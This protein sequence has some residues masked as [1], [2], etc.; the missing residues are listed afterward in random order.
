MPSLLFFVS[1][2]DLK[3]SNYFGG[4]FDKL[5]YIADTHW[6]VLVIDESHEGVNT[7]KTDTAFNY[8]HR[9]HMLYLSGTPFKALASNEFSEDQI[10]NWTYT[11]EQEA[12]ENWQGEGRNPYE[13]MPKLNLF[14]YRMS[15]IA[16]DQIEQGLDING[17]TEEYAFDLNEFFRTNESGHFVHLDAVKQ[18]IKALTTQK[19]FPF[20]TPELRN[21]LK[22]TLW[23]L[24]RVDSAKELIKLLRED[25][26]FENYTIIPAVGDGRVDENDDNQ[27]SFEKVMEAIHG[28][29]E[30]GI[31]PADRTITVS[32][33]QLTTGVTVP[34]WTG[35]LILSNIESSALYMQSAFRA[36]NP[37]LG[38][39]YSKKE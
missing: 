27:K 15:D 38:M 35:V 23:L 28:N 25:P 4:K 37:Y 3:G 39:Q 33:G 11:D 6:D 19:K 36:Q 34:E 1:L 2:Q 17:E 12:K 16:R 7:F 24:D 14:A 31:A 20:S 8:V 29:P 9:D 26:V 18:L 10:F 13:E 5:K 22:H 30:K 32:V 21:E